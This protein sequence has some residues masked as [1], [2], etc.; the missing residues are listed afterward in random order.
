MCE[1]PAVHQ[2][3]GEMSKRGAVTEEHH[4][5]C[6][7]V[8]KS[9]SMKH[10]AGLS[11]APPRSNNNKVVLYT[12]KYSCPHK[13]GCDTCSTVSLGAVMDEIC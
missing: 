12:V 5:A 9:D 10:L 11:P 2:G 4:P 1:R 6:S 3:A 13:V 8:I 7:R